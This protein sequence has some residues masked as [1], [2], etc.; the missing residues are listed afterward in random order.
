MT[1]TNEYT[2]SLE[3]KMVKEPFITYMFQKVFLQDFGNIFRDYIKQKI[4]EDISYEKSR[5]T[6][7]EYKRMNTVYQKPNK[8]KKTLTILG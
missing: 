4:L 3:V 2:H 1:L 8:T 6:I 5:L 7:T